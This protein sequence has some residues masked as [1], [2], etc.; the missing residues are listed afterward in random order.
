MAK[1][2]PLDQVQVV[3]PDWPYNPWSTGRLIRIGQLGSVRVGKRIFVTRELLDEFVAAHT[4]R[5]H[6]ERGVRSE[7]GAIRGDK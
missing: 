6:A 7:V 2:V 1:L 3:F 4:E 5:A